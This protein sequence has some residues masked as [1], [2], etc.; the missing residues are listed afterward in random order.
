[1]TAKATLIPRKVIRQSAGAA[2]Y[3]DSGLENLKDNHSEIGPLWP[4]LLLDLSA[5]TGE[6]T[7]FARAK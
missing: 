7:P 2:N 5:L 1:M 4:A 3:L 6:R